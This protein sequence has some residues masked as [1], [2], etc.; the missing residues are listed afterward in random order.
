DTI[1]TDQANYNGNRTYGNGSK[2]VARGRTVEVGSFPPNTWGLCDTHGN[3]LEWCQDWYG[4]YSREALTD[5][6]G[7]ASGQT[8]VLRGGSFNGSPAD[9]RSAR[10][11]DRPPDFRYNG[12]GFRLLR[13]Q[14]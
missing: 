8:R 12:G 4:D 10:R 1:S 13:T 11:G 3:V 2:G 9:C 14:D 5:P 6:T 7:P